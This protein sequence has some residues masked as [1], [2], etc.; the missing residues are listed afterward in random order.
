M[1]LKFLQNMSYEEFCSFFSDEYVN[2]LLSKDVYEKKVKGIGIDEDVSSFMN[3]II[4]KYI[5]AKRYVRKNIKKDPLY[6]VLN[7]LIGEDYDDLELE[8]ILSKMLNSF[9][10]MT[11]LDFNKL[12]CKLGFFYKQPELFR[13]LRGLNV[14]RYSG[15][16]LENEDNYNNTKDLISNCKI[17]FINTDVNNLKYKLKRLGYLDSDFKGFDSIYLSN[18]PEY[19]N[20]SFLVHTIENDLIDLLADDGVIVYSCLGVSNDRLT[21]SSC[22]DFDVSCDN[23]LVLI[24]LINDING[25]SLLKDKYNVNT[26]ESNYKSLNNGYEDK[27]TFVFVKK[28]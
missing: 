27:D 1:K 8:R 28:K 18:I 24:R 17:S 16:Y 21:N 12:F 14:V 9:E 13:V 26:I 15:S 5:D 20:G 23:P 11:D 25:Y 7:D 6:L 2:S 19:M 10:N 3:V 4:D 22:G